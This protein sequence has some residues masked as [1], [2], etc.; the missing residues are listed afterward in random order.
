MS[1]S[2]SILS[3]NNQDARKFFLKS[4]SYC[5]VLLPPYF[6]F[7]NLLQ[8]LDRYLEN[9]DLYNIC[10]K[11]KLISSSNVNYTLYTNKDGNLSWRPFQLI[12]P[13]MYVAITHKITNNEN[14]IKIQNIFKNF[15]KIKIFNVLAFQYNQKTTKATKPIKY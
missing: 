11:N 2:I 5:N 14:W 12:N 3:L 15:K 7:D 1:K 9:K 8:E 10:N 6:Y 13:I 4:E